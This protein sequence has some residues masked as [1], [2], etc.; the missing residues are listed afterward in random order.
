[1]RDSQFPTKGGNSKLHQTKRTH[2]VIHIN[3]N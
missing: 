3:E 2:W 1:M